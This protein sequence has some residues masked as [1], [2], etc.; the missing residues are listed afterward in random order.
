MSE[1]D[2]PPAQKKS[3][4][5]KILGFIGCGCLG[6]IIA[7]V[8]FVFIV[9]GGVMKVIKSSDA[10]K[11]SIAAVQTNP[12]AI[13]ALGE[14]IEPGFMMSGNISTNNGESEVDIQVPVS[15]PKGSGTIY[16]K[17]NKSGG[18]NAWSYEKFELKVDGNPEPIPLG[19]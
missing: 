12:E 6:I 11:D 16:V 5:G 9:F 8:A 13:E 7:I 2:Q 18:S 19:N 4:T 17:G 15:G 14:P 1:I 10:Y 3:S